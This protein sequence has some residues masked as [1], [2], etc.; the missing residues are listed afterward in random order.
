MYHHHCLRSLL[1]SLGRES[2]DTPEVMNSNQKFSVLLDGRLLSHTMN[3]KAF[4]LTPVVQ[5]C[6]VRALKER[7]YQLL[8]TILDVGDSNVLIA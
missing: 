4:V 3:L 5:I 1:V 8:V 6:Q 7:K 2:T